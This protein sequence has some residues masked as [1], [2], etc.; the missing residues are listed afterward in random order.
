ME[1][2]ATV[3]YMRHLSI[4]EMRASLGRLDELLEEEAEVLITRRG[5]AVARLLPMKTK[6]RLPSHRDLRQRMPVVRSSV[7]LVRA[8]R[9]DRG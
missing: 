2:C 6:R 3:G 4:R 5:K 9:D 1:L 8:D 7:E